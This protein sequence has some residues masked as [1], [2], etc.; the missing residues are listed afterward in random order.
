MADWKLT[1][2]D[3][4]DVSR[5]KFDNLDAML[6]EVRARIEQITARPP[7]GKVN[8]IRDYE[9]DKLVK[10]RIEISGK[11]FFSPP[12]AGVDVRGD[13]SLVVY[14]GSVSRKP[15]EGRTAEQVVDAMRET[16]NQ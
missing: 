1:V 2:R 11:G 5:S 9:P 14:A 3:G 13:N 6:D 10:A 12:T 15:I 8:A 4:S 16:L 7:L